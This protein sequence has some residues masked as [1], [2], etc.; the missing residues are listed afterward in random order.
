[1]TCDTWHVTCDMWHVTRDMWHMTG[2]GGWTFSQNFSSLAHTV[3]DLWYYEDM[4][5]KA[6]GLNQSMS[7]EAVYRTAPATPSL[8]TITLNGLGARS[9]AFWPF[10]LFCVSVLSLS[11]SEKITKIHIWTDTKISD[12]RFLKVSLIIYPIENQELFQDFNFQWI[13]VLSSGTL[14]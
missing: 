11:V 9:V 3:P 13:F 12:L 7:D 10:K 2:W 6:H 14:Q 5:E 8:L 4:E 1:M